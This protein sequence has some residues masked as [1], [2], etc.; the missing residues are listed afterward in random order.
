MP[1]PCH[2][3]DVR[4]PPTHTLLPPPAAAPPT[5]SRI[6][7]RTKIEPLPPPVMAESQRFVIKLYQDLKAC[8]L[9]RFPRTTTTPAIILPTRLVVRVLGHTFGSAGHW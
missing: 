7:L 1:P 3:A 2:M 9:A 8:S 6:Y 5:D 4:Y